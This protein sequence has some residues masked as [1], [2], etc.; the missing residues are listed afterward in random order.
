MKTLTLIIA[1]IA[2]CTLLTQALPV[3]S[4]ATRAELFSVPDF[5]QLPP[6]IKVL[7]EKTEDGVVTQEL[8]FAGGPFNG[9]P[10]RI[11]GYYSRP[12]AKGK[13][14][15]VVQLHGAGLG[16][17]GPGASIFYAKNGYACISIDWA[18]PAKNRAV[19][20]TPPYSEFESPGNEATVDPDTKKWKSY[21][22]DVD[23][24][25]NG[26]RFVKRSFTFLRSRPEVDSNKLCLSGMSA[27]AHLSLLVLGTEPTIKAATVKYGEAFIRDL[28]GYF[29]GY[30][31]PISL[32][33][34]AEQDAWL[35][36]L[37]PK[38]GF[39]N[40]KANVLL[41]SGTDD[42]FFW[43]PIVLKTYREIPTPKCLLMLPNDNHTQVG[44]E[45]IPLRYFQAVL[46]TAPA[47]PEVT[48][49]TQVTANGSMTLSTHV[50]GP[51]TLSTVSFIVKTTPLGSFNHNKEWRIVPATLTGGE[52]KATLPAVASDQQLVAYAMAEDATGARVTSDTMELPEF[53]KWRG[54]PVPPA[55]AAT[56]TP[57]APVAKSADGNL[58][59]DASFEAGPDRR[60]KQGDLYIVYMGA[61]TFDASGTKAH[62]GK[63]AVGITGG[64]KNY[65]T[66]SAPATEGVR[67]RLGGYFRGERDGVKVRLQINWNNA[68]N[69]MIKYD[70]LTPDVLTDYQ[71]RELIAVA[72]PGAVNAILI[73]SGGSGLDETIWMDDIFFGPAPETK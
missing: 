38:H 61:P 41:V 58:F 6:D 47:F 49:P 63:A 65:L 56:P 4:G 27:G 71:S 37:D 34:K 33:P 46:G 64:D 29:G 48:P 8:T 25:T 9:A 44:N 51:S 73:V 26:V 10:T 60:G 15:G 50:T 11:Y 45:Q 70:L 28:P 7:S 55:P 36:V 18:G 39:P 31:G 5:K 17:L 21:G 69:K 53:P 24:I 23:G 35:E 42:I 62:T 12:E 57:A 43:M 59:L 19:P 54:L 13:Y 66:V 2:A 22:P 67:F 40:Y 20:R 30:F 72:P 14:P 1:T 32:T 3:A 16:V 52:W 68:A